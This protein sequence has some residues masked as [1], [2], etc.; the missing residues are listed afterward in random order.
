MVLYNEEAN[1]VQNSNVD[2]W[3][4]DQ[5]EGLHC[6][7]CHS[8][9]NR[10]LLNNPNLPR[11]LCIHCFVSIVSEDIVFSKPTTEKK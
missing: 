7:C 10:R 4:T 2:D 3:I 5:R 6:S 9:D 1:E 11:I 8:E